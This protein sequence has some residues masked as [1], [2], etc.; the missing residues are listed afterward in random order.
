M[1]LQ[2]NRPLIYHLLP[3][4]WKASYTIGASIFVD[5]PYWPPYSMVN[6]I[7][8]VVP[9]PSQWFFH[10]GEEIVIAWTHIGWVRWCS[11]ISHCQR[12]K[13]SVTAE[14]WLVAL[15]WR[16]MGFCTTKCSHFLLSPCDY[17]LFAEVEIPLRWTR[18]YTRDEPIRAIGRSIRNINKDGRADGVRRLPN[19]W[20]SW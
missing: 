3:N 5:I 15:S 18:H 19:I 12:H 20:K 8:C 11:R 9:G 14:V 1:Y 16:I 2:Y 7:S 4:I 13:R 17:D 10:Y 6:F